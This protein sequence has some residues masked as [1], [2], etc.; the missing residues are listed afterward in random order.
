M[1]MNNKNFCIMPWIGLHVRQDGHV[2]PCCVSNYEYNFGNIKYSSIHEIWNSYPVRRFR[3]DLIKGKELDICKD[4]NYNEKNGNDSLRKKVN[5][6]YK[7]HL[8]V[9]KTTKIDGTVNKFNFIYWDFRFSNVCNFKCRMCCQEFSSSWGSEVNKVLG[10]GKTDPIHKID[11]W[12]DIEPL[13]D[14]VEEIYFVGGEPLIMDEHYKI[15]NKLVELEK[16][17]VKLQ[18]NTN[19]SVINY[20]DNNIIETWK[21]F[22][23]VELTISLD[24]YGKRGEIIRKGM[25]W[26]TIVK[27]LQYLNENYGN[28]YNIDCVYQALNS[29]HVFDFHRK[30]YEDK[31]IATVDNFN[32]YFLTGPEYLSID[33]LP[34]EMKTKLIEKVDN[35]INEFL[36]PNKSKI[37]IG[38]FE[39][40]KNI[41]IEDFDNTKLIPKFKKYISALDKIRNENTL[42]TFPELEPI[43]NS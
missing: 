23:L 43:L 21:K 15:I 6:N 12:Q 32:I 4:C 20:K 35:H 42:E 1:L 36:I 5:K 8:D 3:I 19:F 25:N 9:V 14:I 10:N 39:A 28:D 27:N 30:L 40:L 22:D 11:V 31:L 26:D 13:F 24:G 34:S 41:L 16:Y 37:S 29:F 18:Y 33:I 2:H 7:H 38:Q 17:N